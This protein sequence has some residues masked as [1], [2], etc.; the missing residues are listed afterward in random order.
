MKIYVLGQS[1]RRRFDL[2]LTGHRPRNRRNE[3]RLIGIDVVV[4]NEL[5]VRQ[6]DC[7]DTSIV[8]IEPCTEDHAIEE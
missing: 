2:R 1:Q 3:T 6:D 4:A 5:F 7:H 8:A